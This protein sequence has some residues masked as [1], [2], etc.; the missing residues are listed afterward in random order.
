M[1]LCDTLSGL[2]SVLKERTL[3]AEHWI[4]F[5]FFFSFFITQLI[6]CSIKAENRL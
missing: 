6:F 2:V 4:A 1:D 5:G 3:N